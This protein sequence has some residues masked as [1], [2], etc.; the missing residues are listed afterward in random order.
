MWRR[1]VI[2]PMRRNIGRDA[3]ETVWNAFNDDFN[4][5]VGF[6]SGREVVVCS[7]SYSRGEVRLRFAEHREYCPADCPNQPGNN[8]KYV[9]RSLIRKHR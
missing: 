2:I 3:G 9:I 5:D 1:R 7:M 4:D 8:F 6:L